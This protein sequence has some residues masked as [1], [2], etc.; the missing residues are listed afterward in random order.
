[1]FTPDFYPTPLEV[2]EQM[3]QSEN[4]Q[5]KTVLEPS[6]GKGNIVDYCA[7]NGAQV[8]SCEISADLQKILQTKSKLL[9]ADFMQ[10]ES[11]EVSHID[12]IVMNPP[13]SMDVEH[14]C[15][16]FNIAPPGCKII[17]LCAASRLGNT[18]TTSRRQLSTIIE[19]YGR[20]E[21]LGS[22]FSEAE[23]KTNVDVCLIYLQKPGASYNTEFE[24]FFME[25]E[26]EE[27]QENGLMSYNLVRDFVNRYVAA[28]KIYDQQLSAGIQLNN[29]LS[30]FYGSGIGFQCTSN[31][32]PISR[33]EF[34][35]DLQKSGWQ[36]IFS[37][38]NMKK[39]ATRGLKEDINKFVEQ[40]QNVPFTM[41]NIYKMLEIVIATSEQRMDKAIL[42]VFDKLTE[43][44]HDNRHNIEGWKTNSHY[45]VNQRFILPNMCPVDKWHTGNKLCNAY[46]SY[47]DF[48]EDLLKALC[49]ISGDN[50]DNF[51]DLSNFIRYP[52][53]LKN[54][55]GE[56]YKNEYGVENFSNWE[57][58]NSRRGFLLE[59]GKVYNIEQD[60]IEYGTWFEW[61]YFRVKAFKKGTMHFEFKDQELW[62]KFNQRV[63]KLKGYPL[64][65]AK[66]KT[67][68]QQHKFNKEQS[69]FTKK[70]TKFTE[71]I[72]L[73]RFK[74][75]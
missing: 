10:V 43:H 25:E 64:F 34:K 33:N 52:Y 74:V 42:E 50:Y 12:Y 3:L 37:K 56:F 41:R 17:A 28:V 7:G 57:T 2:I 40:Q 58:A 13:F 59:K 16:A 20:F 55:A 65:E 19:N 1:M 35:K 54:E 75:A 31:Q 5:G 24:G 71:P 63:A 27:K 67:T 44:H 53:R 60:L 9:K 14:I 22:C 8:L 38:M 21:A 15:H 6:A 68:S 4:L 36:F 18:Y 48:M 61:A 49:Y 69:K 51:A 70:E 39:Y 73:G 66:M 32:A 62:G 72:I 11:F 45:L 46:G 47:F 23:R 29:L 26:V 30:G